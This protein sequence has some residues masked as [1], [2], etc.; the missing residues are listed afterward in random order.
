MRG[1]AEP[2]ISDIVYRLNDVRY[3]VFLYADVF[4]FHQVLVSGMVD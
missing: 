3:L 4:F 2:Q 1:D